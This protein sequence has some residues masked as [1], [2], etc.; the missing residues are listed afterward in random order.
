MVNLGK[1]EFK[2]LNTGKIA[3][4]EYR[5]NYYA[6]EVPEQEQVRTSTK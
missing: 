6:G 1:Y 2:D 5:M 4:E 3:I